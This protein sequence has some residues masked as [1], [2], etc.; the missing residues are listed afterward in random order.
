M[1]IENNSVEE[2]RRGWRHAE[3]RG[4]LEC[5]VCGALFAEDEVFQ[6]DGRFFQPEK[7]K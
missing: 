5:L 3:E 4:A 7:A 2:I 1:K 6:V